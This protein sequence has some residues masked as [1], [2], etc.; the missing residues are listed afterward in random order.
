V[1]RVSY[2][3]SLKEEA[4]PIKAQQARG[5]AAPPLRACV[6]ARSV[7]LSRAQPTARAA[8]CVPP[9]ERAC[10]TGHHARQREHHHRRRAVREG[11]SRAPRTAARWRGSA[12]A[13][14]DASN[15]GSRTADAVA[16]LSLRARAQVVD[17]KRASYGVENLLYAVVQLAQSAMRKCVPLRSHARERPRGTRATAAHAH[18]PPRARNAAQRSRS[19]CACAFF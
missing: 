13:R 2:T 3:W 10:A 4:I 8:D 6:G 1:D 19:A 14:R 15:E 7:R 16:S 12:H 11:A 17:P 18:A 9:P 5:A